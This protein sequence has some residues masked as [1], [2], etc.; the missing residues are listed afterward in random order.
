MLEQTRQI[1]DQLIAWRRDFHQHPELGFEE[2]RT[3][4]QVVEALRQM[5]LTVRTNVGRT[6]VVASIGSG[7]PAVGIR[8]DMDALP[9]QEA[10]DVPYASQTAGVMHACGHDAHTAILLGVARTLST[11]PD[12]PAGEIRLLFQPCEE[13]QDADG[14]SGAPRMIADGA[15]DGLDAAIALHIASEAPTGIVVIDDGPIH[16][17]ADAFEAVIKGKGGHGAYPHQCV[18]PVQLLGLVIQAIYGIRS[19]RID[20]T[21]PAVISIGRIQAGDASNVIPNEV[22]LNGTIRSLSDDIRAQLHAELEKALGVVRALDGDYTLTIQ[23]GY[24]PLHNDPHIANAIRTASRQ[25]VGEERT[26]RYGFSMGAE[27]FA[28]MTRTVP[29]AMCFVGAQIGAEMRPHHSPIFDIDE[30]ALAIG[31]AVLAQSA[32][33]LLNDFAGTK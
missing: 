4:Q 14:V 27:D 2:T 26:I 17:A 7:H 3:S 5:G 8:A 12:R 18:D 21:Q 29:G 28:Y 1:E 13:K 25:V 11:M 15:L 6:G 32:L 33:H 30:K 23:Q 10:N 16:A 22:R 31:A 24:P 19:R 20:P 9:I